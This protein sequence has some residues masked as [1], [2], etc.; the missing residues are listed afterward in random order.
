MT[1]PGVPTY[2]REVLR[3]AFLQSSLLFQFRAELFNSFNRVQFGFPNQNLNNI[4]FGL[5]N[6]Q[7]NTPRQVQLALKFL[8]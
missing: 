3:R 4:Q 8:F 7:A 1:A 6:S 5:I 2:T